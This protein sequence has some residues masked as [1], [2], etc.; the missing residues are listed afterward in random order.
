MFCQHCGVQANEGAG[1]C[2]KC[3]KPL[4]LAANVVAASKSAPVEPSLKAIA[5]APSQSKGILK[6][7]GWLA[8]AL[9]AAPFIIGITGEGGPRKFF[10]DVKLVTYA[11]E[12]KDAEESGD[13]TSA[14]ESYKK[15]AAMGSDFMQV[16]LAKM[17]EQGRGVRQDHRKALEWFEKA[18]TQGNQDA[19]D[20]LAK[21]GISA[22]PRID[23]GANPE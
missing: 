23:S 5:P 2:E 7:L 11:L 13:F 1:F 22:S 20:E 14:F 15:G 10:H 4:A 3:G 16:Q 21:E 18:A 19:I 8:A 17:Y 9:L 6:T 12:A